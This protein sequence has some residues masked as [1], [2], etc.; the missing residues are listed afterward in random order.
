MSK[1]KDVVASVSARLSNYAHDQNY[2]YQEVLQY[3]AI[4]RF[5]YRLAQSKYRDIF[6]LKGGV[7]F[8]A[9]RFPLRRA[10]RD[11]DLHGRRP[12]TIDHLEVVVKEICE[13]TVQ[14]DGIQFD[15][16]TVTGA[17]IQE[18]AENH[19]IRV[20]FVGNLGSA[21]IHMQ[22]DFG[23]SD[24]LIPA[25]ISVEYPTILDMPAPRLSAY[26][27]E[28]LI[29][30]K[31]QA[32]VFLGSI[33]SRMK[34]FYDVWLLTYEAAIDGSILQRAIEKTFENRSTQLP[35][36]FPIDFSQSFTE[37]KQRQWDAFTNR[38][39]MEPGEVDNFAQVIQRLNDFLLPVI[40]AMQKNAEFDAVWNPEKG[41]KNV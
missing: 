3:Y 14:P 32:M 41:W 37:E 7:A 30:E 33:N 36:R 9:W 13:Q 22:L 18:R 10:T 38:E 25:A 2:T 23:F 1:P 5:L 24:V 8:F 19:G 16:N 6:V 31:F 28:T 15:A 40:D 39:K 20:R 29:A 27:W 12:D 4:E 11:I 21:R 26:S 17:N 34:D 35:D